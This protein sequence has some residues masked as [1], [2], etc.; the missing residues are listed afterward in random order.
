MP[1]GSSSGAT[2]AAASADG[3]RTISGEVGKIVPVGAKAGR[4]L[5]KTSPYIG[6]SGR[7]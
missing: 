4:F 7:H 5:Q 6:T 2:A 3:A 1:S